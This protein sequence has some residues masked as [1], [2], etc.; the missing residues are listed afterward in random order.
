M[1]KNFRF[2]LNLFDGIVL[3]L[4]L[5]VVA[6][7]AYLTLKPADA[8][9]MEGPVTSTIRYTVRFDTALAGTSAYIRPGDVLEDSIKNYTLGTVESVEVRPARLKT[10]DEANKQLVWS[11]LAGYEDI[12]ITVVTTCTLSD[13]AVVL[14]GGY[15]LRVNAIAYVRGDGYMGYGPVISIERGEE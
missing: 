2:K 5:V 7:L 9:E 8:P 14:D 6:V 12:Y 1:K 11:E 13:N 10:V 3:V 15:D 4:G